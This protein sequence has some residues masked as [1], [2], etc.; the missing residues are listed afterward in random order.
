MKQ[1]E[2]QMTPEG[3]DIAIPKNIVEFAL[4]KAQECEKTRSFMKKL[5]KHQT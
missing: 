2:P 4:Y 1:D 5:T 3:E